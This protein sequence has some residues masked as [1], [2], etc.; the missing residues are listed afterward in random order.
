MWFDVTENQ[1]NQKIQKMHKDPGKS[2]KM[3]WMS[4]IDIYDTAEMYVWEQ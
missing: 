4:G 2:F 1:I 3:S